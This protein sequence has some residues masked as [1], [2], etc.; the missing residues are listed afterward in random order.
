MPPCSKTCLWYRSARPASPRFQKRLRGGP[1]NGPPRSKP[2][3]SDHDLSICSRALSG[4]RR[5]DSDAGH[6]PFPVGSERSLGKGFGKKIP[7]RDV[8]V[9]APGGVDKHLVAVTTLSDELRHRD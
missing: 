2:A 3:C 4:T 6:P 5:L 7:D 9:T 1:F 8:G